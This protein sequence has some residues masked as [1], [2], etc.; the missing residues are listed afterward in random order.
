MQDYKLFDNYEKGENMSTIDEMLATTN[1]VNEFS[2][3][4]K[5]L[6]QRII[7]T[8][9]DFNKLFHF[10][11]NKKFHSQEIENIFHNFGD[12]RYIYEQKLSQIQKNADILSKLS[13]EKAEVGDMK[14]IE[15]CLT[16][17]KNHYDF[18]I[19]LEKTLKNMN[20]KFSE[21]LMNIIGDKYSNYYKVAN[22]RGEQQYSNKL[23]DLLHEKYI[24]RKSSDLSSNDYFNDIDKSNI[25]IDK[26]NNKIDKS[27]NNVEEKNNKDETF[28]SIMKKY[29]KIYPDINISRL[30]VLYLKLGF[31]KT[32]HELQGLSNLISN[33]SK[34]KVIIN[35]PGD[36]N[37]RSIKNNDA[38]ESTINIV[39]I[40]KRY[41]H[42]MDD[43]QTK[44]IY[45]EMKKNKEFESADRF[46]RMNFGTQYTL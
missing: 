22:Q 15:E 25:D 43:K 20:E 21:K 29:S 30:M 23:L 2:I 40:I 39:S 24:L 19:G 32:D 8:E 28:Q 12:E 13:L 41:L 38:S 37:K 4:I 36:K 42:V 18:C 7:R 27:N 3:S 14:A 33:Q 16:S 17:N 6:N 31:G 1:K 10:I 26:C 5:K 45:D 34:S 44:I 35:K 46:E 9:N 11:Q